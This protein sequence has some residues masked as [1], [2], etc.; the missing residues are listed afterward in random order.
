MDS[1]EILAGASVLVTGALFAYEVIKDRKE[2]RLKKHLL[3]LE[4]RAKPRRIEGMEY[5]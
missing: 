3:I 5:S 4:L 1:G 2:G